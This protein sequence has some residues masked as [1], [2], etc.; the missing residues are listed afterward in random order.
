MVCGAVFKRSLADRAGGID[1]RWPTAGHGN[2]DWLRLPASRYAVFTHIGSHALL[3]D[4]WT[5]VYRHWITTTGYELRGIP[6][7]E[8]Y[9][10]D[11]G[12]RLRDQWRTDLYL[13]LK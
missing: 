1:A 2:L 3:H 6:C 7:F 9:V 12:V 8:H 13:P 11:P 10:D 4:V 5:S